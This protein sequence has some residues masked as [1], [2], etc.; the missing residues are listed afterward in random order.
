MYKSKIIFLIYALI[1]IFALAG[2]S[3]EKESNG[4]LK[5]VATTT[6]LYDLGLNIGGNHVEVK[7]LMSPGI[8]PHLFKASAGDV[9]LMQEADIVIYNGLHLEG[10]MADVFEA[11]SKGG[12]SVI[13]IEDGIDSSKLLTSEDEGSVYD[14]HI[15][16]D[17]D[18]W[19]DAAKHVAGEF[20]K[21][22]EKNAGD[23]E[24][25][26]ESYL[27]ELDALDAYIKERT[28][29]IGEEQRVLVTAHDAFRYFARAYGYEVKGLQ[30]ISTEAE[31]GTADVKSLAD[32]IYER[33]IKAVF[34]ESSV[35]AKTIE[36]LKA[37]V[38]SRGFVTEIGGELYSDSLGDEKSGTETYILTFRANIDTIVNALK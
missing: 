8:D 36:A 6:M 13:C 5:I 29:E 34:V 32:F 33:K 17:V 24:K 23:Y 4:K 2:C 18:L 37:A 19:K 9:N 12:H 28:S 11:L 38:D 16:F 15:W 25:N 30:G 26:L 21:I 35:P 3:A 31:A 22:D 1:G 20:S 14:P 7:A 27:K 10:K